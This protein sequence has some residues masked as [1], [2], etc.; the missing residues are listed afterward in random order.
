[1][2]REGRREQP[3]FE[4]LEGAI[5]HPMVNGS[6]VASRDQMQAEA[7]LGRKVQITADSSTKNVLV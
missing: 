6:P 1:M 3:L 5:A 4:R 2:G 7:A